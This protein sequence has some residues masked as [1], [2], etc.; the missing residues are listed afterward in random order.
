MT[1]WSENMVRDRRSSKLLFGS[2]I[3]LSVNQRICLTD[4]YRKERP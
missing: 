3:I 1:G 2:A 4:V